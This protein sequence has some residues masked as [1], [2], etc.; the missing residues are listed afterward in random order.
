MTSGDAEALRDAVQTSSGGE[1]DTTAIG[2]GLTC[3]RCRSKTLTLYGIPG[4]CNRCLTTN[5]P[6]GGVVTITAKCAVVV[7]GVFLA[8]NKL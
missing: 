1:T 3:H 4:V 5:T 8:L 7:D 6:A 2:Y